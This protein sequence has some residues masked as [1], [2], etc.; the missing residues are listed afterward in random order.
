MFRYDVT[1]ELP[2]IVVPTL[3][4]GAN[5]DRLTR[6]DASEY[7]KAHIP[8][9]ELVMLTPGNHQGLIERHKEANEAAANFIQRLSNS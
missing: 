5:K 2:N 3:I 4:L 1:K 6:P 7:V 8:N 9:S